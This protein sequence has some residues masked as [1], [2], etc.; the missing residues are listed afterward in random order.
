[1]LRLLVAFIAALFIFTPSTLAE[2]SNQSELS[3]VS[4]SGN[5]DLQ[6]FNG[7]TLSKYVLGKNNFELGG[8]I[9]KGENANVESASNWDINARYGRSFSDKLGVFLATKYENDRFAGIHYRHN[10]DF[11]A[12]YTIKKSKKFNA[13]A[14]LGYRYRNEKSTTG[15]RLNQSQAR[16]YTEA[17]RQNTDAFFTKLWVEY[18]PNFTLGSDWQ[19]NVEPSLNFAMSSFLSIKLGYLYK[20]DNLPVAGLRK[21]D[22][23]YTTTLIAKF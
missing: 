3:I 2:F 5:T 8:R 14:E 17:T 10:N 18:L 4:T 23:Q 6:V 13:K 1:M 21:Y 22:A 7:Q 19:L 9:T 16:L 15:I 12:T 11:G 20:Y